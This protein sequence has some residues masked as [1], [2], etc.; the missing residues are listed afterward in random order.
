MWIYTLFGSIN[1]FEK[2]E[3]LNLN[4]QYIYKVVIE[5]PLMG[6]YVID[7]VI[8]EYILEYG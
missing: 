5:A 2:G 1:K 7:Y 3:I 4:L 8:R 6:D